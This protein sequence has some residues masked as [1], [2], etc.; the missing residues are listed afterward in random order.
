MSQFA[1]CEIT[2]HKYTYTY[3]CLY[4]TIQEMILYR[5]CSQFRGFIAYLEKKLPALYEAIHNTLAAPGRSNTMAMAP[6]WSLE[7]MATLDVWDEVQ[8]FGFEE[9]EFT[10]YQFSFFSMSFFG[11]FVWAQEA[12]KSW[13][14]GESSVSDCF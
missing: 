3:I 12:T 7:L 9:S 4:H 2:I 14:T 10:V 5:L 1:G 13:E 8:S 11:F 6:W